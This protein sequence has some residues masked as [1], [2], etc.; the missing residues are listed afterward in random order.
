MFIEVRIFCKCKFWYFLSSHC[1]FCTTLHK[2]H[3]SPKRLIILFLCSCNCCSHWWLGPCHVGNGLGWFLLFM[4][5]HV[6]LG[7]LHSCLHI[8]LHLCLHINMWR[9]F[10]VCFDTDTVLSFIVGSHSVCILLEVIITMDASSFH[11]LGM[12]LFSEAA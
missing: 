8:M 4:L 1:S 9:H 12:T 5:F 6:G 3:T 2:H 10:L 11:K 7:L